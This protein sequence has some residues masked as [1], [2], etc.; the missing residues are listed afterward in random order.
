MAQTTPN[1]PLARVNAGFGSKKD[2]IEKIRALATE[3]LWINR[4]NEDKSWDSISNAKLLRL[5]AV[6]T[7]VSQ[8]FGSR[9]KLVDAVIA[10]QG[11]EK[12]ADY[13]RH[14]ADWSLPRLLDTLTSAERAAKRNAARKAAAPA[15]KKEPAPAK[16]ARGKKAAA[17]KA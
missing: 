9:D 11:R 2:L 5:H 3:N 12:D 14:F 17:A 7:D 4:L 1:S 16:K 15:A 13:R 6:L 10:A 8:R